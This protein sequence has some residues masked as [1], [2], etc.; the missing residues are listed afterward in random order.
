[1]SGYSWIAGPFSALTMTLMFIICPLNAKGQTDPWTEILSVRDVSLFAVGGVRVRAFI[2]T[3][4]PFDEHD[5]SSFRGAIVAQ[6]RRNNVRVFAEDDKSLTDSG[7]CN[8]LTLLVGV[9]VIQDKYKDGSL[10]GYLTYLLSLQLMDNVILQRLDHK[11]NTIPNLPTT[12]VTVWEVSSFGY[13]AT[14]KSR[15]VFKEW[16]SE[17]VDRLVSDLG[18]QNSRDI[19]EWVKRRQYLFDSMSSA[20]R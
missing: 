11:F 16:I 5:T 17:S 6:L 14:D 2:G 18:S 7:Y 3:D 15:E 20:R 4:Y 13:S 10:T 9:Q 19:H 1:M 8:V 12:M